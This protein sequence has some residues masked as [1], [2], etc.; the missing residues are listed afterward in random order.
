[1]SSSNVLNF[2]IIVQFALNPLWEWDVTLAL[3][4]LFDAVKGQW[5]NSGNMLSVFKYLYDVILCC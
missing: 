5:W 4:L 1:M 2:L 3:G